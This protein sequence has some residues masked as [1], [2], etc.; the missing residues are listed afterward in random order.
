MLNS[1]YKLGNCIVTAVSGPIDLEFEVSQNV[2]IICD[3]KGI[4]SF[5]FDMNKMA[6]SAK[7][8]MLC[9]VCLTVIP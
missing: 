9:S 6:S 1:L 5:N 8:N 3:Q 7:S 4:V 2:M